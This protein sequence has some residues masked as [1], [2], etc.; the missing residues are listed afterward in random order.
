MLNPI[1]DVLNADDLIKLALKED[2][3]NED[4]STNAVMPE[5]RRGSVQLICKQKGIICGLG[6]FER[7]FKILDGRTWVNAHVKDGDAVEK[8]QVLAEVVGDIRVLLSGERVALN[9]LQRMS[10]TTCRTAFC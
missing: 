10:G 7:T 2:I 8:G 6:V 9:Y 1:S 3:S 4:V 5:F